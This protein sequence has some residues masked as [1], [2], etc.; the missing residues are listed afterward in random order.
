[1]LLSPC[2]TRPYSKY[3]CELQAH[4]CLNWNSLVAEETH[5]S[6]EW[7]YC[8][9]CTG[10]IHRPQYF[11]L[12]INSHVVSLI[13]LHKIF[14]FVCLQLTRVFR[15]RSS[16]ARAQMYNCGRERKDLLDCCKSKDTHYICQTTIFYVREHSYMTSDFWVGR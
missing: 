10:L 8:T 2:Y 16:I 14:Q 7:A 13:A 4:F 9:H 15:I 6:Q 5:C 1:M 12:A 11:Q 3:S